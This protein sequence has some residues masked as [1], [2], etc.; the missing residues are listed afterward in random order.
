MKDTQVTIPV[1]NPLRSFHQAKK[2]AVVGSGCAGITAAADLAKA[3]HK[4]T[5]LEALHALG[6]VLRYGI[7]EF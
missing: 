2:V 1:L 3:G 6:G 5:V 7:P 4:V